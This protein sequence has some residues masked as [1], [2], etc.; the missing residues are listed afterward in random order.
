MEFR[1]NAE[2]EGPAAFGLPRKT[3]ADPGRSTRDQSC[4]GSRPR[5]DAQTHLANRGALRTVALVR[6]LVEKTRKYDTHTTE[7]DAQWTESV[8]A[9]AHDALEIPF[10]QCIVMQ[11]YHEDNDRKQSADVRFTV[12]EVRTPE[13]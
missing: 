4:D 5:S 8:I 9:E 11:D 10:E 2:D 1:D 3:F 13:P 7:E 6:A 12:T